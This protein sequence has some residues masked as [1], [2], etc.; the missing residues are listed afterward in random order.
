[1][2]CGPIDLNKLLVGRP[3][4]VSEDTLIKM[5]VYYLRGQ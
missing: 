5:S 2:T 1:M 4:W 3:L